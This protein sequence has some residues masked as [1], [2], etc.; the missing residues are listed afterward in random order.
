MMDIFDDDDKKEKKQLKIFEDETSQTI[1]N[2]LVSLANNIN[3]PIDGLED[4]VMRFSIDLVKNKSLLQSE[5]PYTAQMEKMEKQ[6]GK[7][8]LPPYQIYRNQ[9]I[10]AIVG[11]VLLIAIQTTIPSFQPKKTFPGCIYSF[12]GYPLDGG[13]ENM[14]SLNYIACVLKKMGSSIIPWNSLEKLNEKKIAESMRKLLDKFVLID[15]EISKKYMEKR[16]YLILHPDETIPKEQAIQKWVHFLPPVVPFSI[17]KSL[18]PIS[19]DYKNELLELM[20]KGSKDQREHLAIFRSKIIQYTYGIMESIYSIVQDKNLLLKTISK[21]PFLDNAC[22]NEKRTENTI[23]YFIDEKPEIGQFISISENIQMILENVRELSKSPILYHPKFTGIR[24]AMNLPNTYSEETLYAAFIFYCN[25]DNDVPI[26]E[27]LKLLCSEK[28]PGYNKYWSIQEKIEFLKKNG[29][30]YSLENLVQL[31]NIINRENYVFAFTEKDYSPTKILMQFLDTMN[32]VDS[33][34]IE[35]PIRRLLGNYLSEEEIGES[36]ERANIQLNNYLVKSNNR[37][38]SKIM[39]FIDNYG[40]LSKNDYDKTHDFLFGIGNWDLSTEENDIYIIVNFLKN[41]VFSMSK[42]NPNIIINNSEFT[43]IP[44]HWDLASTH[45]SLISKFVD[46]YI[47]LFEKFKKNT[48]ITRFLNEITRKLTDLSLFSQILNFSLFDKDTILKLHI[49]CLY[50]CIYEYIVLSNDNEFIQLDIQEK[51]KARAQQYKE[52]QDESLKLQT[53]RETGNEEEDEYE[54]DLNE[55][56]IVAG[57]SE[58]LKKTICSMIL[59]FINFEKY[60]KSITNQSYEKIAKRVSKSKKDE[61]DS[62]TSYLENMEVDER[63]IEDSL[64]QYKLE[65]WNA[66]Q[67]KGLIQ[68]D[69]QLYDEQFEANKIRLVEDL[70]NS[71]F[72]LNEIYR[73]VLTQTAQSS[74]N[75]EELEQYD[76]NPDPTIAYGREL[77]VD[78]YY[79]GYDNGDGDGDYNDDDDMDEY[80]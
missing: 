9:T 33:I 75:I 78:E 62:I 19:N 35:Q 23:A 31:M 64:K 3:I 14:T 76:E 44:K 50:S 40:N 54:N 46:S 17:I 61:K 41:V 36:K 48:L 60:N 7:Q 70:N 52:N 80:I 53:I 22:C 29:K 59:V 8:V 32:L 25:F 26:P 45:I 5:K 16:E 79:D 30:R 55:I 39:E 65:R 74:T 69:Q 10:I 20:R 4:F 77:P 24:N 68:Y 56:D 49:Y 11:S 72:N 51:K 43:K 13:V 37:M 1:Y 58:E 12:S 21:I 71:D 18:R 34:I 47:S 6:K 66:G 57:D 42:T 63:K 67:Q 28:I 73:S 15:P 2:I 38:F 27:N